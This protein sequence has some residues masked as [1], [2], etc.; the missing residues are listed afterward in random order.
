MFRRFLIGLR[1]LL[2]AAVV[3]LT[4]GCASRKAVVT[5]EI[6]QLA[7]AGLALGFDIE[8]SDDHPLMIEAASWLGTPYKSG[9][10]SRQGVDCSGLTTEIYRNV[11]HVQLPRTSSQQ[12][13]ARGLRHVGRRHLQ[14][15]DLVFFHNGKKR[16][17]CNHVG[18]YLKNDLFLHTS[19]SRGV[20]VDNLTSEY[21]QRHWLNGGHLRR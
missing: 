15:G 18:I 3:A 2:V 8:Y 6:R 16:K 12:Y 1:P 21:W 11:Y 20:R 13:E 7:R 4:T 17:Q 10:T 14:Q 5:P 19:S 9:G